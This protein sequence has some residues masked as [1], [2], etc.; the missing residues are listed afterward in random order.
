[1]SD[2]DKVLIVTCGG[3]IGRRLK[4]A[5]YVVMDDIPTPRKFDF[6]VGEGT[7]SFSRRNKSDRKRNKADRWR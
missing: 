6:N 2:E 1:M 4:C 3:I 7:N 5:G